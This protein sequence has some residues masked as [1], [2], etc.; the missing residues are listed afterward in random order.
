MKVELIIKDGNP[1]GW[2]IEGETAEEKSVVN[3]VRNLQFFGFEETRI[4]YGGRTGE[5]Y[6][7]AGKLIWVQKQH[8]EGITTFVKQLKS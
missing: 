4:V 7:Y 6:E 3:V 5:G 2:T 8:D 1:I